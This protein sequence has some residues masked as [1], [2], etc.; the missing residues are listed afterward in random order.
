MLPWIQQIF[1]LK[2][3]ESEHFSDKKKARDITRAK[4]NIHL[5]TKTYTVQI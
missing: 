2:L 4:T 5:I 3:G 1:L